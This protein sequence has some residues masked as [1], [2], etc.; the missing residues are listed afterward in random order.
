MTVPIN[1]TTMPKLWL[2][3]W[4]FHSRT[5]ASAALT[6]KALCLIALQ[7]PVS[8]LDG[9]QVSPEDPVQEDRVVV[10]FLPLIL[11]AE[12]KLVGDTEQRPFAGAQQFGLEQAAPAPL[13]TRSSPATWT[14][15]RGVPRDRLRG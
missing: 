3:R 14:P 11:V 10:A 6:G 9:G 1:E 4:K 12:G 13:E 7:Q 15:V 5:E 8:Q 2:L